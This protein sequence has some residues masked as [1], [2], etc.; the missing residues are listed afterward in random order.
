MFQDGINF[1]GTRFDSIYIN[2]NGNITFNG[3]LSTFTPFGIAGSS[4][5]IIAAFF[6]DVDTRSGSVTPT[7]GGTS[8]GSNLV[9][10]DLDAAAGVVTIT[11]DDVGYYSNNTDS[12]NAFQMQLIDTGDGNFS[13]VFRYEDVNWTTGDA[14][15]GVDGHS[16]A[17]AS[18]GY[19]AGDGVHYV[20][21]PQSRIE[22]QMLGLDDN[23][24]NTGSVGI[25]RF[26]V[27]NGAV[28]IAP[29]AAQDVVDLADGAGP[30]VID[31]LANDYDPDTGTVTLE[32]IGADPT[33][34]TATIV[35]GKI[36]YTHAGS[37][38]YS[39]SLSYVVR[40]DEG[41]TTTGLVTITHNNDAP[42]SSDTSIDIRASE[43]YHFSSE[44]FAFAD[45]NGNAFQ[46]L[47][48][49]GL[50]SVGAL[51]L[52]GVEV[53][54]NQVVA[55]GDISGLMWSAPPGL[56]V[57]DDVG[58]SFAVVDDGGT[59]FGGKDTDETPNVFTFNIVANNAPTGAA[60]AAL[61]AGVEDQDYLVAAADLLAGFADADGDGLFVTDLVASTGA[62][63]LD[64]DDGTFTIKAA[65]N[66]NGELVLTYTVS[67]GFGGTVNG[68]R[69]IVIAAVDDAPVVANTIS[70]QSVVEDGSWSFMVPADT[71][72]DVDSAALAL[73]ASLE[74]GGAL[75]D[76]LSFEDGTFTGAPP[77]DFNGEISLV[78]TASDGSSSISTTFMLSVTPENDLPVVFTAIEDQA[79]TAGVAWSFSL[80]GDAFVD[81]DGDALTYTATLPDGSEL[82]D[83][84]SFDTETGVFS[85]TPDEDDVGT[86]SVMVTASDGSASA[87][88]TFDIDI[89]SPNASPTNIT[90]TGGKIAE[91]AEG[92][93]L[94]G[95]L[96]GSIRTTETH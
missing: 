75:P 10:Y 28:A 38:F 50:P 27:V 54:E 52:N 2:N 88:D 78:V 57:G 39:D 94:V 76:W 80:P 84:L 4:I 31:V 70:G 18:A 13:V 85:G 35:D 43:V 6:S 34:G 72:A 62:D 90:L 56:A 92:G 63:I 77:A 96:K 53:T 40:D 21:L 29:V 87:T 3:G 37:G 66:F 30:V 46:G 12:L 58:F 89:A 69:N 24:G 71:F 7:E 19:S 16:G 67:D 33:Q 1:F 36:V 8:T 22:D 65:A 73:T 49:V 51:L 91:D 93:D 45:A 42:S 26:D 14:S 48:I 64:N 74:G 41:V 61:A 60:T 17:I 59:A 81:V 9:W 95:T 15:G 47:K 32:S 20:E 5:P 82:P 23:A 86:V 68:S 55:V 83:W 44:D 25:W 79:T 11:W